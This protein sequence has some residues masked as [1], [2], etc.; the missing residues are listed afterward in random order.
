MSE[1]DR[2]LLQ[3]YA[4]LFALKEC[5]HQK[6][7]FNETLAASRHA[8][9]LMRQHGAD[10]LQHLERYLAISEQ[11]RHPGNAMNTPKHED[12]TKRTEYL[13]AKWKKICAGSP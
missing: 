12:L 9:F 13:I 7:P 11:Q 4:D 5:L 3:I 8:Q 6:L 2:L 10:L 1:H